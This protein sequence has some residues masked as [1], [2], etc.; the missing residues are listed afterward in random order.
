MESRHDKSSNNV[1]YLKASHQITAIS[2]YSLLVNRLQKTT[3]RPFELVIHG[4][5]FTAL[6]KLDE[7]IADLTSLELALWS[8]ILGQRKISS[9]KLFQPFHFFQP[10]ELTQIMHTAACKFEIDKS[11]A[12]NHLVVSPI[13]KTNENTLG[14]LRGLGMN[15][16]QITVDR[17]DSIELEKLY[18]KLRLI[19]DFK[20]N[21]VGVQLSH[22]D[23]LDEMKVLTDQIIQYGAPDYICT[24]SLDNIFDL[25]V[26]QNQQPICEQTQN[27][28]IEV[29][30]DSLSQI[31]DIKIKGFSDAHRYQD[32]LRRGNLPVHAKTPIL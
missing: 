2:A 11:S 21:R 10:Y 23:C 22:K 3:L 26:N 14:L 24:G 18:N 30:L 27:D 25:Y 17:F 7:S 16:Y 1:T 12:S 9:V 15:Q 6:D 32:A 28:K 4:G 13:E 5:Q 19:R 8:K 20:F 29:G 31:E